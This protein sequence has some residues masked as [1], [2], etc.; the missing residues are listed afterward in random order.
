[1]ANELKPTH[2]A[3]R[4]IFADCDAQPI[5]D[6]FIAFAGTFIVV[7]PSPDYPWPDWY[8][9]SVIERMRSVA[10]LPRETENIGAENP[11]GPAAGSGAGSGGPD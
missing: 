11:G 5:K 10:E 7:W 3:S 4:I 9:T 6:A 2:R 1:M 8:N